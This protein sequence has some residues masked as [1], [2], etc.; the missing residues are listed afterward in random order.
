MRILLSI[1]CYNESKNIEKVFEEIK[2]YSNIYDIIVIDNSSVDRTK[3][4][5]SNSGIEYISHSI[6]SGSAFGTLASY[7]QYAYRYNYD[8]VCQFDG[9]GQHIAEELHKIITPIEKGEADYVIGS[10]FLDK[11][12]FQSY[13]FRRIGIKLFAK[14][15]SLI[16][17]QKVT[18][19]TSGFRAYGR[20]VIEL[21]GNYYKHEI[22]DTNQLLLLSH[23]AGARILE[24]PVEMR[25]R[26]HGESE[27]NLLTSL[28]YPFKGLV[29]ILGTLLQRNQIKRTLNKTDGH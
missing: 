4:I 27:F 19:V 12:G 11:N 2:S 22:F 28:I 26:I 25:E 18:D 21:F 29:N 24:V 10:R 5:C 13:L 23:F 9:D 6:N 3:E 15:D 8:I 20:N 14:L 16:I 1:V 7:F 17:G